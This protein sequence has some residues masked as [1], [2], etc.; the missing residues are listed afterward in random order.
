MLLS[1]H[2]G[3]GPN[4]T[5]TSWSGP[6]SRPEAAEKSIFFAQRNPSGSEEDRPPLVEIR[7]VRISKVE[8]FISR[9][10]RTHFRFEFTVNGKRYRGI[11][12]EGD[13]NSDHLARLRS[14]KATLIG[15]WDT[16]M[17]NPSFVAKTVRP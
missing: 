8:K 2:A 12:F 5:A 7:Q 3:T 6:Q 11:I 13:W 1:G 9:S 15:Y 16:H 14:G 4:P 17:G 10:K